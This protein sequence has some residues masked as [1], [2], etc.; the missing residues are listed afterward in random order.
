QSNGL[1]FVDVIATPDAGYAAVA[2]H[3]VPDAML[4][5]R[6]L[7][8]LS[9]DTLCSAATRDNVTGIPPLRAPANHER[10]CIACIEGKLHRAAISRTST[11]KPAQ[12]KLD[13][14]HTDLCGP[15]STAT[16][17]G[18]RYFATFTD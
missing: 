13:L 12:C 2:T 9:Y 16:P 5:H 3:S 11:R 4:W 10:Q 18:A 7:G 6:R 1:Y 15:M 14:I 17:G 8:H